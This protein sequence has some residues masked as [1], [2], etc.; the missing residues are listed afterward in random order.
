MK[1]L[2]IETISEAIDKS[3]TNQG[4]LKILNLSGDVPL[5]PPKAL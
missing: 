4:F 1:S 2:T 5:S 3:S